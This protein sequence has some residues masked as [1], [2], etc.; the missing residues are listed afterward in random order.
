VKKYG[1]GRQA[2]HDNIIQSMRFACRIT[3]A[4]IQTH[5]RNILHANNVYANAPQCSIMRTLPVLLNWN[6]QLLK[7]LKPSG[8]FI[9]PQLWY[10]EILRSAHRC[11]FALH[12]PQ[13]AQRLFPY[14]VLTDW[15]VRI[16]QTRCVYSAVRAGYLN[17]I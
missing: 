17:K 4:R 9:Y 1:R 16:T 13:N 10:L 12:R 3:K 14:T 2:T 15:F 5:I 11:L 8:Y 6:M 7:T